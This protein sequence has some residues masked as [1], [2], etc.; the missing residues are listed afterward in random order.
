[1]A[2]FALSRTLPQ[3]QV[4]GKCDSLILLT[5]MANV[6]ALFGAMIVADLYSGISAQ[7][8]VGRMRVLVDVIDPGGVERR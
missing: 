7:A 4:A 8:F 2:L 3:S 1:M 5:F 6:A